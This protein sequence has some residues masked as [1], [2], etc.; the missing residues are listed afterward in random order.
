MSIKDIKNAPS[1]KALC[2]AVNACSFKNLEF[3]HLS[4]LVVLTLP[5]P[6]LLLVSS[7]AVSG[8]S[9]AFCRYRVDLDDVIPTS[10]SPAR[11]RQGRG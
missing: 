5:D 11:E 4:L 9:S 3:E 7:A 10:L 6:C 1:S 2:Y 8:S